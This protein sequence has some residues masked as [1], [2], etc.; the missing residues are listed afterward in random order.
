MYIKFFLLNRQFPVLF[1]SLKLT[2]I[3]EM[4]DF[5]LETQRED[6]CWLE[7]CNNLKVN[8]PLYLFGEDGRQK[9]I[10][11]TIP[12]FSKMKKPMDM[13]VVPEAPQA[14]DI[15]LW[16]S[17]LKTMETFVN[18]AELVVLKAEY[19]ESKEVKRRFQWLSDCFEE[20]DNAVGHNNWRYWLP[21]SNKK[22]LSE[23][24]GHLWD[25]EM[26]SLYEEKGHTPGID[27][28][29]EM[30]EGCRH[31]LPPWYSIGIV[32]SDYKADLIEKYFEDVKPEQWSGRMTSAAIA[33]ALCS[34]SGSI[35]M[36]RNTATRVNKVF[37]FLEE[38]DVMWDHVVKP[39]LRGLVGND[40]VNEAIIQK[41]VNNVSDSFLLNKAGG[42]KAEL[43]VVNNGS[44]E[45]VEHNIDAFNTLSR[46]RL[47]KLKLSEQFLKDHNPK[48]A[49]SAL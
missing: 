21:V 16:T 17:F 44:S 20:V 31:S 25:E 39:V 33:D 12:L 48:P 30:T 3:I 40:R 37:N 27:W 45:I 34:A 11:M 49:P 14:K 38:Q 19:D 2:K 32:F 5:M 23:N 47:E 10:E 4:G 29:L 15:E 1:F 36:S 35:A 46:S 28:A 42:L 13:M 9:F 6:Q 43:L 18:R 7:D 41:L 24:A 22:V 26:F 8:A